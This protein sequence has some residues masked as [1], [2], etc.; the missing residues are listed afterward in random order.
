VC[1]LI[2]CT[3]FVW[4]IS[5]SKKN[6]LR[7]HA[8]HMSSCKVPLILI[9]LKFHHTSVLLRDFQKSWNIKS[10]EIPFGTELFPADRW[11]D[12][13]DEDVVTLHSLAVV[14]EK[15]VFRAVTSDVC[16][17]RP[18]VLTAWEA[19]LYKQAVHLF[20]LTDWSTSASEVWCSED[21]TN[22]G[23]ECHYSRTSNSCTACC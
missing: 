18:R 9:R 4:N 14:A 8:L 20:V 21:G 1:V 22:E 7:Y 17:W 6:S 10:H 2:F 16:I 15:A 12:R 5:L 13:H 11:T 23:P 3:T 19:Q